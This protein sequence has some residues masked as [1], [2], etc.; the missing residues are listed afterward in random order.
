[1]SKIFCFLVVNIESFAPLMFQRVGF[2][3]Y[4]V[5]VLFTLLFTHLPCY[6]SA[7]YFE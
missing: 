3:V 5:E 6:G 7:Q 4:T 1:M 2:Y